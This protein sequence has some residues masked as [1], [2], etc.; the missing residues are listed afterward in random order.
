MFSAE[1]VYIAPYAGG[2]SPFSSAP[3]SRRGSAVA[4]PSAP[5]SRSTSPSR[6][7]AAAAGEPKKDSKK[8]KKNPITKATRLN[9]LAALQI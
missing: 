5:A 9:G 8:E 1:L 6:A 4:S 7:A 2:R 3:S